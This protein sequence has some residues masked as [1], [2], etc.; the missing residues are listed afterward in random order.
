MKSYVTVAIAI[1]LFGTTTIYAQEEIQSIEQEQLQSD[2]QEELQLTAKDSMVVSSWMVGLGWN[3]VNDTGKRFS[4]IA[5]VKD[6]WNAVAFP[7]RINIGRYFRSGIG[8]EA[9]ATYNNYKKGNIIDGIVNPEDKDYFG[10]DTRVSYDL[11]KL[12]G[13]TGFFD[14]Y[15]GVGAGYT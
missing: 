7:S 10:F 5:T 8:L 11:N 2:Q 12:V 1:L 14:P 13:Q 6:Q 4:N 3:F 15:V 9:I